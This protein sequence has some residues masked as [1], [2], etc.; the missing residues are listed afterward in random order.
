MKFQTLEKVQVIDGARLLLTKS[1]ADRRRHLI[2]RVAEGGKLEPVTAR[3]MREPPDLAPVAEYHLE[4]A[5]T[6]KAGEVVEFAPGCDPAK[7][8]PLG[9]MANLKPSDQ[10]SKAKAEEKAK[11]P[12]IAKPAHGGPAVFGPGI[13]PAPIVAGPAP[14]VRPDLAPV[15]S[16]GAGPVNPS[17]KPGKR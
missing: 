12:K 17:N 15:Q 16:A 10:E 3:M 1:Q 7:F 6:F 9:M 14:V 5:C 11:R 4:G 2:Q 13:D 8:V